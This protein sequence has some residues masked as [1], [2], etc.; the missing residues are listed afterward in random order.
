MCTA[1]SWCGRW[2][3][4][5]GQQTLIRGLNRMTL[6]R[7]GLP[8]SRGRASPAHRGDEDSPALSHPQRRGPHRGSATR[9]VILLCWKAAEDLTRPWV[10]G[11]CRQSPRRIRP[12]P[13][14]RDG[15]H[16]GCL[17]QRGQ[18]PVAGTEPHLGFPGDL[19]HRFG[20]GLDPINL[21][22]ANPRLQ[23]IRPGA[24]DQRVPGMAVAGLGD[25]A[26]TDCPAC[27]A[28]PV[29]MPKYAGAGWQSGCS[30]RPR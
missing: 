11:P 23:A 22:A 18:P 12:S 19:T 14:D 9:S 5:V 17:A 20:Q 13:R 8:R 26:A 4:N 21:V 25:A 6:L 30:R 15:D 28:L 2:D 3:A 7:L 1:D 24:F 10:T 27:R 16:I 29:T